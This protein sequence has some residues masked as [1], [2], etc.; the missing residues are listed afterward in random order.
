M[1]TEGVRSQES[2]VRITPARGLNPHRRLRCLQLVG[3]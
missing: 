1:L 3:V 2:G